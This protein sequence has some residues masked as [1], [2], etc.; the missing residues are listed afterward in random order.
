MPLQFRRGPAADLSA[1]TVVAGEPLFDTTNNKLYI[2]TGVANG[3]QEMAKAI[4]THALSDL[5]QSAATNGQVPQWSTS[6]NSWVP[7]TIS[8]SL[9]G[10]GPGDITFVN[11]S[12]LLG[13]SS[14]S[15]GGTEIGLAA[16]LAITSTTLDVVLAASSGLEKSSGLKIAAGGITSGM[17]GSGVVSTSKMGVDVTDA[18]KALL[19]GASAADQRTTLGLGTI[20]TQSAGNVTITGG[21]LTDVTVDT[22]GY[23][24]RVNETIMHAVRKASVGTINKGE[25]VRITGSTGTNLRV[26]LANATSEAT[27]T[28]TI[29]IAAT[30]ITN[31]ETGYMMIAGELTGLSTVPSSGSPSFTNGQALWLSTTDGVFTATRPTQPSHG[32]FLGWVVNASNGSSGRIYVKVI[33]FPELNELHDVLINTGTLANNDFLVYDSSSSLWKNE[34]AADARTSLGLGNSATLN[35]GTTSSTVALGDHKHSGTD[36][37]MGLVPLA[38]G[39]TNTDLSGTGGPKQFLK[40][41]T[42]GGTISVGTIGASDLPSHT[43]AVT[44]LTTT[45]TASST[46]F[47]RGDGAWAT[48]SG[49]GGGGTKTLE[50]WTALDNHPPS[51]AFATLDTRNSIAVLDFDHTTEESAVFIGIVPESTT[52]ASGSNNAVTVRL[53]WTTSATSGNVRWGAQF[54]KLATNEDLGAGAYDSAIEATTAVGGTAGYPV[55]TELTFTGNDIGDTLAAGDA[56]RLKVY[57]DVSD[58]ADTVNS[59]DAE[60]IAVE[61]RL[62]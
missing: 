14:S 1:A 44:D 9:T 36:I 61:M 50:R 46:T 22:G 13:S 52:F 56:F 49:G 37:T 59:N 35:T 32:V 42:S 10:A 17:L 24:S 58:A 54:D 5:T 25:V 6:S 2:G 31:T 12:K 18:G 16:Q 43:H 26:E 45:G 29:G 27:S 23:S 15:T 51:T 55:F 48:P 47:L 28:G 8:S 60:L 7:A 38:R 57:R 19:V 33:N 39:G 40:Q 53:F 4:H 62:V 11:P 41:L 30:T 34:S 3:K 20:A 21:T